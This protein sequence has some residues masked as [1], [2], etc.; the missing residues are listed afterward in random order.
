ML[1]QESAL[2]LAAAIANWS[3]R[4]QNTGVLLE[5]ADFHF[6]TVNDLSLARL[7]FYIRKQAHSRLEY[8]VY[9]EITF[10]CLG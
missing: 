3:F 1:M 5:A 8:T 7:R 6:W 2:I 9:T 10:W 4:R